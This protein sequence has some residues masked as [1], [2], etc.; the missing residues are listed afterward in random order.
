VAQSLVGRDQ[1]DPQG[2]G[3]RDVRGVVGRQGLAQLP[4]TRQE[5]DVPRSPQGQA[6]QI[7]D[8]QFGSTQV[9][10]ASG[11]LPSPNRGDLQVDQLWRGELFSA[12]SGAGLLTVPSVV[13]EGRSQHAGIDNDHRR[14]RSARRV[15]TAAL[16]DTEPPARPP[17]R[18]S[19]SSRVGVRAS[20][21]SRSSKYSCRDW[22]AAAAR[23]RSVACTSSGTSFTC[24]LGMAPFWRYSRQNASS[25]IRSW[26]VP[27]WSDTGVH[28]ERAVAA[29][30]RET[31]ALPGQP[32]TRGS[33]RP[34]RRRWC[35]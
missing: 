20:S 8:R 15:P 29:E 2:F 35:R 32:R 19:T 4:A 10:S 21:V 6:H 23:R 30:S 1:S 33:R 26:F 13:A 3:K 5:I 25:S 7:V 11:Q 28:F 9:H 18:S 27:G 17:A 24:T 14:S 22:P 16:N 34:A 12:Q 31:R